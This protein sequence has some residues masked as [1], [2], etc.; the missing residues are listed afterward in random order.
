MGLVLLA[1]LAAVGIGVG[2]YNL[3]VSEG[4]SR[5]LVRSGDNVEVVRVVGRGWGYGPGFGFFPFGL[6]LFPLLVF[7]I[8]LL[9]R[10]VLWRGRWGGPWYGP[11]NGGP[12]P[13]GPGGPTAFDEWHRRQHEQAGE[14]P[15]AR[16]EQPPARG[17]QPPARGEQATVRG[18]PAGT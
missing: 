5:E 6:I 10:G 13:W 14:Q 9:A 18:E 2:A 12:G 4:V 3:G 7:G 16:G 1:V 15:P 8:F 17:E 11:R